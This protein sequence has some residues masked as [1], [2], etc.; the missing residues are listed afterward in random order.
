MNVKKKQSN[1][2]IDNYKD[3]SSLVRISNQNKRILEAM[4][5]SS[6]DKA[7]TRLLSQ[8]MHEGSEGKKTR[9]R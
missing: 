2:P 5:Y 7:I 9:G 1:Q 6:I 4:P 8:W 3:N